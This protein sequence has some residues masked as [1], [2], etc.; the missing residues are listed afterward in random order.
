MGRNAVLL[1]VFAVL[2]TALLAFTEASTRQRIADNERE[3]LLRTIH[4]LIPPTAHD[5]DIFHDTEEVREPLLLG[6]RDPM[7]AY[8]AR[9][10]GKP[11]AVI[12]TPVAPDGYN[13][14]IRL[15]VAIRYD[16]TLAGVRVLSQ[17][18]TPGLGD[19]IEA[20]RSPW[21]QQFAGKSLRNPN[22]AG[23]GVRRDGG[24]FDQLTGATITPRAVVKAVHR[25]LKFYAGRREQL[26]EPAHPT[27]PPP[28]A[29]ETPHA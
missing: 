13:G 17:R 25:A 29:K 20:D 8:R 11:V 24:Q 27:A 15:L 26:F 12:L 28:F 14:S 3:A 2:G 6:T 18:E 7:T 16:G 23:W 22:E 21:I 4:V 10:D 9:K 19:G 1:G 5:N